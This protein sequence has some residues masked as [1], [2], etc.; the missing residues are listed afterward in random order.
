MVLN[1]PFYGYPL[2][3]YSW[4]WPLI[5]GLPLKWVVFHSKLLVY[6]RVYPSKS[7]EIPWNHH[8][9]PLNSHD[10]TRDFYHL[11]LSILKVYRGHGLGRGHGQLDHPHLGH[12]TDAAGRAMMTAVKRA[13][14]LH[15]GN[16]AILTYNVRPPLDSISIY[17]YISGWILIMDNNGI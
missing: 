6:Q 13:S 4:K 11:T 9:I 10:F 3:Q 16:L 15:W 1:P 2:I 7:H 17:I 12:R 8:K 14:N 5:V